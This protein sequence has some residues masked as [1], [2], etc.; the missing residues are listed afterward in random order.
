MLYRI[1]SKVSRILSPCIRYYYHTF[2]NLDLGKTL[3]VGCP[4]IKGHVYIKGGVL[5]SLRDG[6]PLGIRNPCRLVTSSEGKIII[7][8]NFRASG[9]VM[10]SNTL[11]QIG[12]NV[13]I[14]P[15]VTIIDDD[16]HSL[17]S[18]HRRTSCQ[19]GKTLPISIEDDVWL[20]KSVTILKGVTIGARSV[21]GTGIVISK[22]IPP[23]SIV[24]F[25]RDSSY[26]K[27]LP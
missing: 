22:S 8:E 17:S 25:N 10:Y 15:D 5:V 19:S 14:G 9:V 2:K 21:I 7:G 11:I 16:M 3:F 13:M 27:R 24:V 18:N 12:D 26:V 20:G 4:Y 23:D 1:R 6:N